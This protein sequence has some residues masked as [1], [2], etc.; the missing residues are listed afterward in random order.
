MHRTRSRSLLRALGGIAAAALASW[1]HAAPAAAIEV[2][3]GRAA[4]GWHVTVANPEAQARLAG[5]AAVAPPNPKQPAA[6]VRAERITKQRKDDALLL[7][8]RDTWYASLRIEGGEAGRAI[9]LRSHVPDGVLAFDLDV[10][11]MRKGGIYFRFD[12]GKDCERKVPYVLPARAAAGKGWHHVEFA[13]RC[14]VH[15]GDDLSAIRQ[16]FAIEGN[17]AGKVAVANVR[18]KRHG[19]PNATCPDYRTAS[20]T[21]EPLTE[22]WALD[23][24]MPR[25]EA[26]LKEIAER[27]ASGKMPELVFIGDSITQGWEKEGK[28]EWARR[29]ARYNALNL[30]YGGDRTENILWRLQH[31]EVDGLAPKVAVLMAGTNNT[32]HRQEAPATTAAGLKR[33]IEE[34]RRRMPSTKVLVLGIFPRDAA[35][36]T[37]YRR[38]NS[39]INRLLSTYA[40]NRSVFYHDVS[41]A[42][43]QP[44]GTLPTDVMP[45]LLHPNARGYALWAEALEPVLQKL[46]SGYRWDSVAIGGGGFVTAVVPTGERGVVYAR[47]D[48]G[49]AYRRDAGTGRWH[50]LQDWLSE[51]Q[52]GLLGVD[53]LAVDPND[54]ARVYL[55]A[56]IAY[57]NG[58]RTAVLRS[59]DHGKSF[60]IT[61]VTAQFKTHGNGMGRQNGERLAVDPG[62]GKVLYAGSRANG[63]FVS[64]DAGATW[65]R[66]AALDVT[67]T[68]NGAGIAFVLPDPA[69]AT[70]EGARRLFVGVSR[71]G[72]VGPNL[73]RSDDGGATFVPVAGTPPGLMP[74]RAA[75]D[76]RGY[77]YVTF[78]DGAGPHPHATQP[79][80]V[81]QGAVFR[82]A[83]DARSWQ[84]V[85]PP[86]IRSAFSGIAIDRN[87]PRR[88]LASTINT[89]APQGDAKGDRIFL[90]RDGGASWTDLVARGFAR[91]NAGIDWIA[92]HGIHWTGS[93]AFDPFDGRAAWVTSGNGVFRTDDVDATPATW[94]FDVAGMEETVPLNMASVPGG[95]MISVVGDVDGF[96]H[97]DP[98][99]YSPTH[100]PRMGT[101]FGLALAGARPAVMARAGAHVYTTIDGGASW[102]AAPSVKG[103]NGQLALSADGGVL[104]HS[105]AK[106]ARSWRTVDLGMRWTEVAGLEGDARPVADPVDPER[107][108]AYQDGAFLASTDGGKSFVVMATLPAGGS[109][110][111]GTAPGRAG[112]VWVPLKDGG[113]ARSIDGG[114]AFARLPDVHYCGAV[115]FGRA[116]DGASY[117]AVYIWGTVAG[118]RGVHRSLDT[119]LTWQRINDDA[120]QYGGPGDGRFVVG[121]M[122]VF[123]RVYMSTAG[124]GIV[125]GEAL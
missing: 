118:R 20:V 38:I 73:Y 116:A 55:L 56:G 22:P 68:P 51:D 59:N 102:Q 35:P 100:Q 14:F 24:W 96:V 99:R 32:G 64:M 108:Y 34:L 85:T 83:I 107:F 39:D 40:D 117:P 87:D 76:R 77:L 112:D 66:N 125:Y 122:N 74:H 106:S 63:L 71:F 75:L 101:T 114:H 31:G 57:L 12:C 94:R 49:G 67:T 2:Y 28:D 61:D 4:A 82:Y 65:R 78:A 16:P 81:K 21:P 79:E 15:D 72:S 90:S 7:T 123:G 43:L 92:G 62:D 105:P 97:R 91:D 33:I 115:G 104:L 47:T 119:G 60:A 103:R 95:P 111:L 110:V 42:F 89:F 1:G 18:F 58:G 6:M 46:L 88:I 52:T 3:D 8:F 98:A 70:P 36:D 121:D 69:S 10:R 93:I 5:R 44:D 27:R 80:P 41:A 19:K 120:H 86:G 50:A 53:A 9:D 29:Y 25:H 45:D 26:K 11:D 84:D 37:R 48:V 113:L 17:G 23:W 124:R 54:A 30:G 109:N 13:L